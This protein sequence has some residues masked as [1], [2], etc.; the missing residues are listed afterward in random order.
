M[1]ASADDERLLFSKW[2]D[3][4][5][6]IRIKLMSSSLIFEAVG[7]V[8]DFAPG[9]LQLGGDSWQ[10]TVPLGDVSFS[11]SD[12]REIPIQSVRDAESERYEFALSMRLPNGDELVLMELKAADE[13]KANEED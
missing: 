12:P 11:F 3:A 6:G 7:I 1:I 10:F 2:R 5:P 9:S 4:S 13:E 8:T